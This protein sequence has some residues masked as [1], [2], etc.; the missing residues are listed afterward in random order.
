[1]PAVDIED[2]E[3]RCPQCGFRVPEAERK[4]VAALQ[5]VKGLERDM[6][7][8]RARREELENENAKDITRDKRYSE[9][10]DVLNHWSSAHSPKARE[11]ASPTRVKCVLARLRGGHTVE[12]LK[13]A[14]DGYA[15]FPFI[16]DGKRVTKGPK[17]RRY[18][19]ATLIYRDAEHVE[20]GIEM[21]RRGQEPQVSPE[22]TDWRQIDW[23]KVRYANHREILNALKKEYGPPYHDGHA[24]A[25]YTTCPRCKNELT[26]FGPDG[27]DTLLYCQCGIDEAAFFAAL[28]E[29]S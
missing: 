28:K 12:G 18:V 27:A 16:V 25:D 23:R 8:A 13:L 20:Q 22:S 3:V 14:S 2:T 15:R 7:V 11:I 9:A 19:A 29:D 21:A 17:N 26:V 4:A 24:R 5:T 1:M 6:R 10:V